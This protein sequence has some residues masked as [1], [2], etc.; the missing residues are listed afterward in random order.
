MS[1]SEDSTHARE[2][3]STGGPWGPP[4]VFKGFEKGDELEG[5]HA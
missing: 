1:N 3:E 2:S 4:A 5:P